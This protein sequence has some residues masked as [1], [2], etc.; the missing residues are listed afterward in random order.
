MPLCLS[1][2]CEALIGPWRHGVIFSE[3]PLHVWLKLDS[4]D[5]CLPVWYQKDASTLLIAPSCRCCLSMFIMTS[6]V[7]SPPRGIVSWRED[8][9]RLE[10]RILLPNPASRSLHATPFVQYYNNIMIQYYNTT[11]LQY[12][13]TTILQYYNNTILQ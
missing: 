9:N 8:M 12:Y 4:L 13:T 3:P 7:A 10:T 5:S 11:I 2:W 6:Q 1:L